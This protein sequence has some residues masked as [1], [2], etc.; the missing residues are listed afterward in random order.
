MSKLAEKLTLHSYLRERYRSNTQKLV[1]EYERCLHKQ[2]RFNNHHIFNLR[3]RDEGEIP[4]SLQIAPPVRT[5]KGYRI[6]EQ[7][8]RAFLKA[9][10]HETYQSRR[11]LGSKVSEL[12]ATLQG[13][14]P[15]DDLRKVFLLSTAEAEK[16]HAKTKLNQVQ[17]L[18]KL[19]NIQDK[20]HELCSQE[21]DR[22]VIN[23]MD[24]SLTE[25][26]KE[27]LRLGLNFAPAPAKIPLVDTIKAVKEGAQQ[28]KEEDA[29]DL[30]GRVCGILGHAK[31]PKDNLTKEQRKALK[32]LRGL[33]DE[34]I[35][36]ADKGNATV[37][38]KHLSL[39]SLAY[40]CCIVKN[41]H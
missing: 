31:P 6:A 29:E 28:L 36:P 38:M 18:G 41:T 14:L 15:T 20:R 7:A 16:T 13:R 32:E 33:E 3:C 9:R 21:L 26:Q 22:L 5:A 35:L 40:T 37:I 8:S 25:P 19:T 4:P 2:A 11:E 1:R 27:V 12:R 10:I 24:R 17:K 30:W 34:V 23:L 39:Y